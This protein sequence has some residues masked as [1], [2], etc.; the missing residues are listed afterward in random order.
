M[1][2]TIANFFQFSEGETSFRQETLAGLTVFFT[3]AYMI[4]LAP[5]LLSMAGMNIQTAFVATCIA[6][7]LGS[8]LLGLIGN[9]PIVL[10]LGIGLLSYFAFVVAAQLHYSW[11]AGLAM[12]LISGILFFIVTVTKVRQLILT[13]IPASLGFSIAAGIG[14]FIG[15]IALSSTGLI[16]NG[17]HTLLTLAPL[18]KPTI[19]LFFIGFCLIALLDSCKV[20][21]AILIGIIIISIIG[22]LIK[23]SPFHGIMAMPPSIT[24]NFFA[25]DFSSLQHWSAVPV[26]F[27]FFIVALFD[28]TGTLIGLTQYLPKNKQQEGIQRTLVAESV[29][30]MAGACVGTSTVT[31]MVENAAGIRAGGRTGL[32]PII[33]AIA[34]LLMLF[35]SPI[36][37]SIPVYATSA[38][39]FYVACMYCGV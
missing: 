38:A 7:A 4:V 26:I 23:I 25:F 34:F 20:P 8:I 5:Q 32:T 24:H 18:S 21:G 28:S 11:Q 29:A 2:H 14:A 6:I 1:K 27:T 39:L 3:L 19:I 22:F 15:L 12:V 9:Y 31:A 33:A 10:A 30:I 37:I 16:V 13:A 17:S 35:F 36:A